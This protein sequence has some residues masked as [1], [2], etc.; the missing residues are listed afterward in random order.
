V[1]AR[2]ALHVHTSLSHDGLWCLADMA[3]FFRARKYQFVCVT[4]HSE[5]MNRDNIEM[6]RRFCAGVSTPEFCVIPGIE[7]SCAYPLHIA[8]MGCDEALDCAEPVTVARSIREAGGFAVLAHPCRVHWQCND[9]LLAAVNAVEA[10]NVRYDGKFLP[11]VTGV[12]FLCRAR[13]SNPGILPTVG[14]DVHA[15]KGFYPARVTLNVPQLDRAA[16]LAALT[17]GNFSLESPLWS[18][19]AREYPSMQGRARLRAGRALLNG[20]RDLRDRL[21]KLARKSEQEPT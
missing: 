2:G 10:W 21:E 5:D 15:A 18:L 6:L 4:E 20:A 1:I 12:E 11:L 7:Y 8:G 14:L 19:G 16:I 13:K 9:N 17:E 3:D